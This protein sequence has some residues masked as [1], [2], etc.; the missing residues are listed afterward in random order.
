MKARPQP[1]GDALGFTM[2][3]KAKKLRAK[4]NGGIVGSQTKGNNGIPG[5]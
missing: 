3:T 2:E 4:E 1:A 5:K